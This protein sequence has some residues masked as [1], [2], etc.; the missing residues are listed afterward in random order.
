M[1]RIVGICCGNL[2]PSGVSYFLFSSIRE[3]LL[4]AYPSQMGCPASLSFLAFGASHYF[5]VE[6]LCSL[7]DDLLKE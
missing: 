5:S 3:P 1:P 6:L 4:T 2:D 7:L